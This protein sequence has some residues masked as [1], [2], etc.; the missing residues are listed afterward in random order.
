MAVKH[1]FILIILLEYKSKA[2]SGKSLPLEYEFQE[3]PRR[4]LIYHFKLSY[5]KRT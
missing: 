3:N 2:C 4:A 1:V 5:Q